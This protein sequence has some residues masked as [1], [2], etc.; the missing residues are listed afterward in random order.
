MN[1]VPRMGREGGF[2]ILTFSAFMAYVCNSDVCMYS[3]KTYNTNELL[4]VDHHPT[5]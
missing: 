1:H 4:C 5:V 2:D 3:T